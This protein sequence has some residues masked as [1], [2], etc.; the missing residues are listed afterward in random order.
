MTEQDR[1]PPTS[2]LAR[3][4][5]IEVSIEK[6]IAGGDG[7]A[8]HEGL[9]IFIPRSA[10]GDRARVRVTERRPGYARA[11]IVDLISSGPGR[12]EP[13]CRHFG[14]CGGCDLQHLEDGL[15]VELKVAATRETLQRI[16]RLDLPEPA[17]LSGRAWGYRTRTQLHGVAT[18]GTR[19]ARAVTVGYH[20]RGSQR[21][22][23]VE[24]CPVLVEDLERAVRRL[25]ALFGDAAPKRIDLTVGDRGALSCAPVV[26]GLPHGEVS[27]EVGE[28]VYSF[29]ARC[30]F[31]GHRDLLPQLVERVVGSESGGLA[32]D[33]YAGVGLF[34]LPLA[35]LYER[36]VAVEGDNVASRF[37]RL[38]ARRNGSA[39]VEVVHQAVESWIPSL[40]KEAERL[41]LDPPRSGLAPRVTGKLLALT[42]ARLTY[43]SCHPAALARDL[44][45]LAASYRV[46][47]LTMIDLFPQ[48]GHLEV[49]AQLVRL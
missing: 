34:A 23:A 43:V 27:V 3:F 31:Q 47:E 21:L 37:G 40:P 1:M 16:G 29:D 25:P 5:E 38:N 8:R 7:L 4:D 41:V 14:D 42:P 32:V 30:F 15:Q 44:R 26:E 45:A 13:V 48:T 2:T 19:E 20:A 18:A 9:P 11:E 6:L 36:V 35:R 24:E 17:V 49:V 22:V 10:P 39:N 33:L 28:F 12:R 46:S